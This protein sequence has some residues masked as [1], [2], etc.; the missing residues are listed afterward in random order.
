VATD[1]GGDAEPVKATRRRGTA[2]ER[3]ILHA[4]AQQLAEGGYPNLTMD[5]VAARAGTSKN[6]IYRRWPNR[7]A[8][9]VAAY[10]QMLDDE[11]HGIPDTGDLR[12]DA[13]TMLTRVNDR[14]S[15]PTGKVL[16]ELLSGIQN[17]PDRMREI[18]D[19]LANAAAAAWLTILARAAARGEIS[20]QALV[21]R[22]ATAAVDLLR[23]EYAV[24]G[25]TKA[26]ASTLAEIL[27]QVFLPL[28]RAYR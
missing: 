16:R 17:D 3:A 5:A 23:N 8:L 11:P 19:Q 6:V 26:P 1:L 18:R 20:P 2:L 9:S 25:I 15:S 24:N 10:R 21:P 14:M 7:A 22:V 4:A 27:D 12:S 28:L 13:L